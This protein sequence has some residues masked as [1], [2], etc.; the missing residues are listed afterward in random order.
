MQLRKIFTLAFALFALPVIVTAQDAKGEDTEVELHKTTKKADDYFNAKEYSTA[1]DLYK[2]AM[3][4]EKSRE[5]KKRIT[6][7]L[8]ECYRLSGDC[9]KASSQYN[10]AAKLGYGSMANLRYADMVICSAELD[11][12]KNRDAI[13]A[14]K[15]ALKSLEESRKGDPDNDAINEAID[16]CNY[17]IGQLESDCVPEYVVLSDEA[18]GLPDIV[19]SDKADLSISFI[20]TRRG[21]PDVYISSMND[22]STG[23]KEDGWIGQRYSDIF[24]A[25]PKE[26]SKRGR[27]GKKSD[28]GDYPEYNDLEPLSSDF[29][30]TKA[31]E[32][33]IAFNSRGKEM[34][35]T[36]CENVKNQN[37][38]CAIWKSTLVGKDWSQAEIIPIDLPEGSSIGHPALSSDDEL[39]YF[40]ADVPGSDGGKDLYV[41]AREKRKSWGTP[42]KLTMVNTSGDELH[43]FVHTDGYL[44]FSSNGRV[45]FGGFDCYKVKLDTKG[46]PT[47]DPINLGKNINSPQDDISIRWR[48]DR[49][50]AEIGYVVS[51]REKRQS[52]DIYS[53]RR[54]ERIL[55]ANFVLYNSKT[56]KTL[57]GATLTINS[58]AGKDSKLAKSGEDG[59][60]P[61]PEGMLEESVEYKFTVSK[62][63][64]FDQTIDVSTEVP[65]ERWAVKEKDKKD[66]KPWIYSVELNESKPIECRLD[67]FEVPIVLPNVF[68]DLAKWDLREESKAALDSVYSILKRN[69]TITIELR[70]H[71]DYRDT[72]EK[73]QVLSQ[74]RAQS[75]VDYL[76][77]KGVSPDRLTA[78][79]MGE[80]EPFAITEKYKG[81]G[82]DLFEAGSVLSESF[83]RRQSSNAQE[84]ANQVNRRTDFKVLRDDYV[85]PVN[86]STASE[87]GD[88]APSQ[89]DVR[90]IG[91]TIT[92]G[93]KDRSLSKIASNN[94]MN[95]VDLKKLNGGLRGARP[96]PG[97]VLKV[98][99]NGDY[100][101][102][103]ATHY[104]VQRGDKI[105]SIAKRNGVKSKDIKS[106][107]GIKNDGD[108]IIGSWIQIK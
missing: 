63:K 104:Q 86:E 13:R 74:K 91:Q 59:I 30:N 99:K 79:G 19:N 50:E 1:I 82:S 34:Y 56:G 45:G 71:T 52:F 46:M 85:P 25:T 7:N 81:L 8:G 48:S 15:E 64:F 20:P 6:F 87:S 107:N 28:E 66:N 47:G 93:P 51:D 33:V 72:E 35:F 27:R 53:V 2:K 40:A 5:V 14:Y 44:Y 17:A 89:K 26:E 37:L 3:S 73:N 78:V 24:V 94:G 10:R 75:C 70:S 29:I 54:V 95:I 80:S 11:D 21:T 31:H 38:G 88:K 55:T 57:E 39:L 108:L 65:C 58:K 76:I 69:P 12:K 22:E 67:P 42:I 32:G 98:T 62:K 105:N 36:R 101:E 16:N 18:D 102:F 90:P 97:M 68:F 61:V 96:M 4:K 41:V 60:V 83:I 9:R 43:P 103:D 23:K 106:L 100:T 77:E 49:V 92:L 84:I